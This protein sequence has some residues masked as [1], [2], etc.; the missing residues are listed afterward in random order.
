MKFLVTLLFSFLL[1]G[2]TV[3]QK[4]S[5]HNTYTGNHSQYFYLSKEVSDAYT[6]YLAQKATSKLL[7]EH[8]SNEIT[9]KEISEKSSKTGT[10][11][12]YGIAYQNKPVY[13]TQ[14]FVQRLR[15]VPNKVFIGFSMPKKWNAK[16][17]PGQPFDVWFF[18]G[19][20]LIPA[21]TETTEDAGGMHYE[22]VTKLDGGKLIKRPWG[23]FSGQ[24]V[25]AR[26]S[27]YA[28]D[29][30][31]SSG[32]SYSQSPYLDNNDANNSALE[33]EIQFDSV[34]V[35]LD[36][37]TYFLQNDY[38]RIREHSLP[39]V[40]P[41]TSTVPNF[42]FTRDQ[43]GF[44]DANILYHIS[45]FWHYID[46][47]DYGTE[48]NYSI[49]VDA[50]GFNGDD[51][52]AFD[53]FTNPPQLTFGEGGV[54]DGED[55]DVIVHEYTHAISHALAPF[56]N[57]GG[58][59]RALDEGVCDYTAVSYSKTYTNHLYSEVFNWDGHNQ[60]WDGR[61][62]WRN[63]PYP[64]ALTGNF[65]QNAELWS[66][67]LV[68]IEANLNRDLT[69]EI[70]F[71]S[72]RN[73]QSGMTMRQAAH[74]FIQAD[75]NLTGGANYPVISHILLDRGFIQE[76]QVPRPPGIIA[77][78]EEISQQSFIEVNNSYGFAYQN[79][80][81]EVKA[82]RPLQFVSV[83]NTLGKLVFRSE[84]G[85]DHYRLAADKLP[86]SGLYI[87][88]LKTDNTTRVQKIVVP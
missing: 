45:N 31:S 15:R 33:A 48:M 52:S 9:L 70:L 72:I 12:R 28:P 75:S 77:D 32:S 74:L 49:P 60:F 30:I 39:N 8:I 55:A 86:S 26:C 11:T 76:S 68:H 10:I 85:S 20:E 24:N 88:E 79:G 16:P 35:T 61:I 51:Q 63:D 83:Y 56:T 67:A 64:Q 44:E 66:S 36:T 84:P 6:E 59:R 1:A 62:S 81:L 13:K 53:N 2:Y 43:S 58:E 18:D 47:L 17:T 40:A 38:V 42:D 22:S 5:Q 34:E 80:S 29:P 50:H 7:P 19:R 65:Y 14:L 69:H 3:G 37:G 4:A 71:E 25:K 27:H 23:A 78:A 73:Y 57:S 21:L 82:S 46:G 87:I 54:D 41:V